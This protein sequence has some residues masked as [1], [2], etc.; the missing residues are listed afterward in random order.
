MLW[1]NTAEEWR[2]HLCSVHFKVHTRINHSPPPA[3]RPSSWEL[4][5]YYTVESPFNVV[6]HLILNF[7]FS[8]MFSPFKFSSVQCWNLLL[9]KETRNGS[10]NIMTGFN[11]QNDVFQMPNTDAVRARAKTHLPDL[12][13]A[14]LVGRSRERFPVLSLDFS[15]TYFLPTKPWPWGRLSP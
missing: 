3:M 13:T 15:V 1:K 14:L 4:Y 12:G 6:F 10:F 11:L 9:H 2:L 8:V 7:N 5:L